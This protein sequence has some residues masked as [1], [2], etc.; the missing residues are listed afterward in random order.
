MT[1][2]CWRLLHPVRVLPFLLPVSAA[3]AQTDPAALQWLKRIYTATQTL[4]YTGTFVYHQGQQ[5][6]T[7]RITRRRAMNTNQGDRQ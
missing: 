4:S 2:V 6:E 7:T 5:V 1:T 3:L